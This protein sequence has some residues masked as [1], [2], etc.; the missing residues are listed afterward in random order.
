MTQALHME[1]AEAELARLRPL[2]SLV[3]EVRDA[4]APFRTAPRGLDKL[5]PGIPRAVVLTHRDL[6][7]PDR[8]RDALATLQPAVAVDARREAQ[9]LRRLVAEAPK[10][11]RGRRPR[12][13]VVG[14]PNVGKS[15]VLNRL[16]GR[17]RA[18]TGARP[19]VTRG[20]QWVSCG[21]FDVLDVPGVMRAPATP[22]LAALGILPEGMVSD[23]DAAEAIWRRIPEAV[24]AFY[25]LPQA[26]SF[27]AVLEAIARRRNLLAAGAQPDTER[28]A[29][30]LVADYRAGRLGPVDWEGD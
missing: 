19:G 18:R 3:L 23:T 16:A 21:G 20:L 10:R 7:H 12:I 2:F 24:A 1:R 8:L 11:A 14:L 28:A 25:G 13:V 30:L 22:E 26:A 15:S 5:L 29:R 4:R 9:P 27:A 17:H 6:A